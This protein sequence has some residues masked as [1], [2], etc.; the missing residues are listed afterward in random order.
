MQAAVEL[1]TAARR[2]APRIA[3][4]ARA[5]VHVVQA[6]DTVWRIARRYGVSAAQ[7]ARWNGLERPDRIFPGE[8]LRVAA[9]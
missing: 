6:G 2:V 4:A 9:S 8:H 1:D 7:L 3:S 5:G